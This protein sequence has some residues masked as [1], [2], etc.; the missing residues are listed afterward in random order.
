MP[1]LLACLPVGRCGMTVA[2]LS[3]LIHVIKKPIK[4]AKRC[5]FV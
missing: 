4:T 5:F 3:Y 1:H 2:G